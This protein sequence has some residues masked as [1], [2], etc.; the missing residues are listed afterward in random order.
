M[1]FG[2]GLHR[3]QIVDGVRALTQPTNAVLERIL[4]LGV[5]KYFN[6]INK[7]K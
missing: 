5:V 4:P 7:T 2:F 3:M 6:L 1:Y